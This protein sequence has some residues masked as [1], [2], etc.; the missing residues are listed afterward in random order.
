M[1]TVRALPVGAPKRQKATP[2]AD[3]PTIAKLSLVASPSPV[4]RR[5][6]LG[7]HQQEGDEGS[8]GVK[9]DPTPHGNLQSDFPTQSPSQFRQ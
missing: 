4:K 7:D 3:T 8:G 5:D 6:D 1:A 2:P 9:D